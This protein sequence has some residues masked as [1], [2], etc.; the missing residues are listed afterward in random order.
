MLMSHN[1][2][3]QEIEF[4]LSFLYNAIEGDERYKSFITNLLEDA[5]S[6]AIGK[7]VFDLDKTSLNL[8]ILIDRFA[9]EWLL[10]VN[11]SSPSSQ[12]LE[13]LQAIIRV[14]KNFATA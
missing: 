2:S 6:L 12:E 11:V 10:K 8:K 1:S 14:N 7:S 3:N 4:F 5:K 13:E 9:H